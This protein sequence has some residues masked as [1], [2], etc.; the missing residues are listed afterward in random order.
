MREVL[1]HYRQQIKDSNILEQMK[2][3]PRKYLIASIHREE[4]VDHPE[5]LRELIEGFSL[6]S[7]TLKCL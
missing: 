7:K 2:L 4:N 1:E 5:R 3:Q 6:I